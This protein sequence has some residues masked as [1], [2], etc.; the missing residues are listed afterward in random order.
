MQPDN[1]ANII[2][3]ASLLISFVVA[4][5]YFRDRR[6]AKFMLMNEYTKQIMEWYSETIEILLL[7]KMKTKSKS[8]ISDLLVKLS[9]CIE[10][11]RFFFPNI[12]RHDGY[13]AD[14]P[15]AFRG[16]RN[17]T[18]D[19]LVASY[20]LY[21]QPNRSENIEHAGHL[22]RYFTSIIYEV[23]RPTENLEQIKAITD[24]YYVKNEI[25]EDFLKSND[26]KM[27]NSIWKS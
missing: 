5:F 23:I 18:L 24:R 3:A 22:H 8:D 10:R 9:A 7:L 13:G 14:K 2:A 12:D 1:T 15:V 25:F 17:L 19:F 4:Y 11:G 21:S 26:S 16:Y 27:L 20:N 6:N